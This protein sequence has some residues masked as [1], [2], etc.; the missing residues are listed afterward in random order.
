MFLPPQSNKHMG[1]KTL[2]LDLD[3]TL[4]HSDFTK[5]KDKAEI[6]INV[7]IDNKTSDIYVLIRPGTD[8]FLTKMA[9]LFE[10][11]V[12]TASISKV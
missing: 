9:K 4:V 1:K 5:Y 12:F 3:E 6:V 8:V 7:T 2:V 11:V 10:I